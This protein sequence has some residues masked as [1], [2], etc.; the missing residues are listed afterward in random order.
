MHFGEELELKHKLENR[1][2]RENRGKTK[3]FLP[4]FLLLAARLAR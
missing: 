2:K 4:L 1:L 3:P